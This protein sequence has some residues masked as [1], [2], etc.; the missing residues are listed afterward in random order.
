MTDN[1]RWTSLRVDDIEPWAALTHHLA[2]VDRT[3]EFYSPED[4]REELESHDVE[5][6]RDT[7]AVWDGDSLVG[8]GQLWISETRDAEGL[9]R[10]NLDGGVHADHRG[11]GIGRHLMERL[12]ARA[13]EAVSE[14]HPGASHYLRASGGRDGSSAQRMLEHR[15]YEIARYFNALTRPLTPSD[16]DA[17]AEL[18][19][20]VTLRS[21]HDGDE[22]AAHAA[23]CAAFVDH[24]GSLPPSA[25]SWHEMW[26]GNSARM[27]VSTIAV[28]ADGAVLAYALCGQW[29]DNELYVN[30][31]GTVPDSRGRGLGSA[32]LART[33]AVAAQSG[34]YGLIEL[35][36][37]SESLTGAV[38][39]YERLGFAL[40]HTTSAMRRTEPSSRQ[41]GEAPPVSR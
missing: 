25:Q 27:D 11:R 22:A 10:C 16:A 12:E 4:L 18:P 28:D 14:R 19:P 36:V 33:I 24:W 34:A 2:V 32:V 40:K 21:P 41:H 6:E 29:V 31:V 20:G 15:G 17:S 38:R 26:T 7:F 13:T 9:V 8:F 5:P 39:L 35:D 30:I 37:D 23:H 1:L 3:D